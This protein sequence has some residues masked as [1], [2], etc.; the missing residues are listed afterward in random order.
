MKGV[1]PVVQR[2]RLLRTD[3]HAFAAPDAFV[4]IKREL[5]LRGNALR[6]V[7]PA[8]VQRASLQEERRA[9]ARPVM[10][11]E[12]SDIKDFCISSG[13]IRRHLSVYVAGDEFTLLF[14]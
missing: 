10:H 7:A 14:F 9:D 5:R 12:V 4:R 6:I 1:P 11:G 2:V 13:H 3:M 8:A